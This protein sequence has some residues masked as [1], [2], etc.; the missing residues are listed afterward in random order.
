MCHL[1]ITGHWHWAL[2]VEDMTFLRHFRKKS[3]R[4]LRDIK[5]R[6]FVPVYN[7]HWFF[8]DTEHL[9][10]NIQQKNLHC[11]QIK[12]HLN[13]RVKTC[14]HAMMFSISATLSFNREQNPQ[15]VNIP[16]G[17]LNNTYIH[18]FL[19]PHLDFTLENPRY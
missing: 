5:Y 15:V 9:W 17:S 2:T 4:T 6:L 7:C 19:S 13:Y 3:I 8:T 1:H 11:P 18:I 12:G 16:H 10:S 14:T